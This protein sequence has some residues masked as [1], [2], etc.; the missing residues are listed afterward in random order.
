[1]SDNAYANFNKFANKI[2]KKT[3]AHTDFVELRNL[4]KN[5]QDAYV[6]FA[7]SP[8]FRPKPTANYVYHNPYGFY[9]YPAHIINFNRLDQFFAN[10]RTYILVWKMTGNILNLSTDEGKEIFYRTK[11]KATPHGGQNGDQDSIEW[12]KLLR[13][14]G[15][16]GVIDS[17]GNLDE[18]TPDQMIALDWSKVE[19]L[20][21]FQ[22]PLE[23]VLSEDFSRPKT[24][25]FYQRQKAFDKWTQGKPVDVVNLINKH[26]YW[27]RE[28]SMMMEDLSVDQLQSLLKHPDRKIR[29]FAEEMI[30]ERE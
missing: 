5:N 2:I 18:G 27:D 28:P 6:T 4:I 12:A 16:D 14:E 24:G 20:G 21:V 22:N 17:E 11:D 26:H 3:A 10:D 9:G 8:I 7:D 29:D 19:K 23:G 13:R 15:Y 30:E 25:P 1:M